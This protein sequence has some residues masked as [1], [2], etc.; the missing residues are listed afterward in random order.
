MPSTINP[1]VRRASASAV[2]TMP[3]SRAVMAGIALNKC[4]TPVSPSFI[5]RL[6]ILALASL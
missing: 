1:A 4:V 6:T 2:P 5:A 3:G